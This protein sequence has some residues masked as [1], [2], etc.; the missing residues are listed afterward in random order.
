MDP[1][2]IGSNLMLQHH[3]KTLLSHKGIALFTC[4]LFLKKETSQSR[5]KSYLA[6]AFGIN[7]QQ[8]LFR[9][10]LLCLQ[11]TVSHSAFRDSRSLS[12]PVELLLFSPHRKQ[13]GAFLY[14]T[15]WYKLPEVVCDME[16]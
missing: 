9:G 1:S 14:I 3:I 16:M 5:K 8:Q 11:M 7:M 10:L 13:C 2:S 15:S 12:P 4:L 6:F